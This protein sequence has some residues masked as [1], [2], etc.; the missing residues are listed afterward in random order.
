MAGKLSSLKAKAAEAKNAVKD[1]DEIDEEDIVDVDDEDVKPAK[2]VNKAAV[3]EDDDEEADA[4]P[5]KIKPIKK[6]EDKKEKAPKEPK[7]PKSNFST[8]VE[9]ASF[10]TF[11]DEIIEAN[12]DEKN[13]QMKLANVFAAYVNSEEMGQLVVRSFAANGGI[14]EWQDFEDAKAA[15]VK[16]AKSLDWKK[17]LKLFEGDEYDADAVLALIPEDTADEYYIAKLF[18]KDGFND[19]VGLGVNKEALAS[20]IDTYLS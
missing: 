8:D 13:Q 12:K 4:K 14:V 2:K 5:A 1:A 20:I 18:A 16:R 10:D 17:L 15:G 11:I 7:K 9:E 19:M 6:G 3:V